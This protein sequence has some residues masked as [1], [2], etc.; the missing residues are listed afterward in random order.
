AGVVHPQALE[1]R[2]GGVIDVGGE[3]DVGQDIEGGHPRAGAGGDEVGVDLS[4]LPS[5]GGG[6]LDAPR[7]VGQVEDHEEQDDHSRPAHRPAG[8]V[9]G[10]VGAGPRV[11]GGAGPAVHD[12]QRIG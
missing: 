8:V 4:V 9:G 1:D 7:Q 6:R 5:V 12:R 10:Q 3:G 11:V 2:P